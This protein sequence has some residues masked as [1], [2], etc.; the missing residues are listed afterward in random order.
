MTTFS[1][2][3]DQKLLTLASAT[4]KR[5]GA[6]QAAALRDNTGRTYVAVNISSPSLTLDACDSVFTVA[7]ASGISGIE[8]VVVVGQKP[9]KVGA[10]REFSSSFIVLTTGKFLR[11]SLSRIP[12]I[13]FNN[14]YRSIFSWTKL[15]I[16]H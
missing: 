16:R 8:S 15:W 7:M 13:Q 5:T 2:A 3:E 6:A 11:F 10:L 12:P 1:N 14:A 9:I 4:L